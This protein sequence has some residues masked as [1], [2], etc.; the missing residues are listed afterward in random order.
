MAG[1]RSTRGGKRFKGWKKDAP[2]RQ[3][4]KTWRQKVRGRWR[5]EVRAASTSGQRFGAASWGSGE[6]RKH[7]TAG[8]RRGEE[9]HAE[10]PVRAGAA[11]AQLRI[12]FRTLGPSLTSP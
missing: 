3:A 4:A 6:Q 11:P 10:G 2:H 1:F 7:T 12:R 8:P 5:G 9:R